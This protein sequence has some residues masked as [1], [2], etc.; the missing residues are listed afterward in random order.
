[1]SEETK[2]LGKITEVK[3]GKGG[4]QD[5]MFGLTLVF[6]FDGMHS[7]LFYGSWPYS[8]ERSPTAQWTEKDRDKEHLDTYKKLQVWM[9]QAKVRRIEDL[10]N[11]PVEVTCSGPGLGSTLKSFRILEE[12]L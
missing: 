6:K 2:Y 10:K 9:E 7:S 11:T 5:E 1:M 8:F 4:Y 3:F 12:V